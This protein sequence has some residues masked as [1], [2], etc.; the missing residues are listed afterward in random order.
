MAA[1]LQTLVDRSP[2]GPSGAV[3]GTVPVAEAGTLEFRGMVVDQGGTAYSVFDASANRGFWL[4]EGENGPIRIKSYQADDNI[5][6]VDQGGRAVKLQLKRATIQAG[7]AIAMAPKP[8]VV[9]N[10]QP[11]GAAPAAAV[12]ADARRLEAVAAE[13]RR[14]RALRNAAANNQPA[15]ATPPAPGAQP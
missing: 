3:A 5:L 15:P 6:E 1:D 12:A 14:R 9:N 10:A 8:A 7:A 4:R 13:V 2:F 11:G